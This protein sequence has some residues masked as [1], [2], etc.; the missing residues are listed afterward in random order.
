MPAPAQVS[1]ERRKRQ[2]RPLVLDDELFRWRDLKSDPRQMFRGLRDGVKF[3][4][5]SGIM[6]DDPFSGDRL[7]N[8]E[9]AHVPVKNSREPQLA[10]MLQLVP[11]RPTQEVE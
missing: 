11:E 8:H 9:V 3:L 7:E 6:H 5:R 10:Q 4:A 1:Q 2:P